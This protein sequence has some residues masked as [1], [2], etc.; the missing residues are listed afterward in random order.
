MLTSIL[1]GVLA[2]LVVAWIILLLRIRKDHGIWKTKKDFSFSE[3]D[4]LLESQDY[5]FEV[6]KYLHKYKSDRRWYENRIA[7]GIFMLIAVTVLIVADV[8]A[9][10]LL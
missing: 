1:W 10:L 4:K 8:V 9:I 5:T 3:L 2:I 6:T 7:R